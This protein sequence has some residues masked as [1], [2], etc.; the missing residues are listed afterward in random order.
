MLREHKPE[1][2]RDLLHSNDPDT[3]TRIT[4]INDRGEVLFDNEE[5]PELMDNHGERPEVLKARAAFDAGNAYSYAIRYSATQDR[6]LLYCSTPLLVDGDRYIL[7]AAI[8]IEEIDKVLHQARRDMMLAVLL[9]AAIA[10]LIASLFFLLVSRPVEK[11][12]RT[13][14]RIAAGELDAPLPIP[15]RGAIRE[16]ALALDAM[17][18]RLKAQIAQISREKSERDAIFSNLSEGVMMLD[19]DGG[20]IDLNTAAARILELPSRQSGGTTV[21]GLVRNRRLDEFIAGLKNNLPPYEMEMTLAL[22]TGERHLRFRAARISWGEEGASGVLLVIYDLT[23][24]RRLENYRR[25][26]VA[27]VSHEIKTPITVIRGA[28]E[29]LLDGAMEDPAM[30]EKFLKILAA[31][32]Q[33]LN[34]LV[35]DILSLSDLECRSADHDR[36]RQNLPLVAPVQ[37]AIEL[38][39]PRA[40]ER[41][42]SIEVDDRT[43]GRLVPMDRALLEQAVLNLL[44]NAIKYSETTKPIEVRLDV[45]DSLARIS[46]TDHGCGI[47]PEH[48]GRVFERFY[49]V[50]KARSRKAGGTGLGLAIVKHIAQLHGGSVDVTSEVG[51]GSCFTILLPLGK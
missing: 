32:A 11:L 5:N 8:S 21:M 22:P 13:A 7:R 35:D 38:I 51:C 41:N 46:V 16:L 10:A 48:L 39:R 17:A 3:A 24:I 23:A 1:K 26:F 37:T 9:T 15:E 34:S 43:S 45:A 36:E 33:R 19:M 4:L 25:D 47:A 30:A 40:V 49:R 29:T 14:R 27:N 18:D 31:H 6:R 2:L 44:T 28:V 20:I 50:D 12:R 42:M